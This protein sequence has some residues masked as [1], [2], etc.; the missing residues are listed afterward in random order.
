MRSF[1]DFYDWYKVE[2][3]HVVEL[4]ARR[5]NMLDQLFPRRSPYPFLS[6]TME[7]CIE[8]GRDVTEGSTVYNLSSVNGCGMANAVNSLVGIKRLVFQ[9][10]QMSLAELA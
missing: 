1:E 5:L 2:M 8:S 3:R 9:E 10:K 4:G 7:G 6:S